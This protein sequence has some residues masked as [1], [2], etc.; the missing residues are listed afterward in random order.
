VLLNVAMVRILPSGWLRGGISGQAWLTNQRVFFLESRRSA[1][2]L[3]R[4]TLD[5]PLAEISAVSEG[6]A[7]DRFFLSTRLLRRLRTG[8]H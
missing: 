7:L 1:L 3:K 2:F 6:S 8:R 4:T 5:I